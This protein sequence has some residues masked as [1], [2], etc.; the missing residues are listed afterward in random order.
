MSV[1]RRRGRPVGDRTWG[2]AQNAKRSCRRPP[3]CGAPARDRLRRRLGPLAV[4]CSG[5]AMLR[6]AVPRSAVPGRAGPRCAAL[7]RAATFRH[8]VPRCA[9]PCGAL[10]CQAVPRR[11]PACRGGR[12]Q[13]RGRAHAPC[14]RGAYAGLVF[15]LPRPDLSKSN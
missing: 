5:R 9:V 12:S 13:A 14:R 3:A 10:P 11:A 7:R 4:R 8:V 15:P 2:D 1:G 6:R